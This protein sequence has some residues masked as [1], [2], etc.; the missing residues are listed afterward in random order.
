MPRRRRGVGVGSGRGYERGAT[1]TRPVATWHYGL[2]ARW[3]A[4]RQRR[5]ET[6]PEDVAFFRRAVERFGQPAL[7]LG[8]G[9]GRLLLP[10]LA[11]G[12]DVEGADASPD[13]LAWAAE[14]AGRQ[15]LEPVLHAQAMHQLGLPRRYRT[16]FICDS[17][18][19]GGDRAQ[20]RDALDRVHRHLEPGGVLV[21]A[22]ELPYNQDQLWPARLPT[23]DQQFPLDWP[24]AGERLRL[25]DGEELELLVRLAQFDP[26]LQRRALDVRARLWRADS[27]VIEEE[28]ELTEN[29]Y[30][31]QEL[32]LL[33]EA[34]GFSDIAVEG[35]YTGRPATPE[36]GTV[37]V[38]AH[39][40]NH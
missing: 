38:V 25:S 27:L 4:E 32:L 16:I 11:M 30:F 10:L 18:G 28:H 31:V 36:D 37:V 6:E 7:D 9:T 20:D 24:A 14:L 39:R 5:Q 33:L 29:L 2:M 13:M 34:C 17:F 35:R 26:L 8:C 15:G 3:W 19:I 12:L 23:S 40:A 21:L 1:V 22:H